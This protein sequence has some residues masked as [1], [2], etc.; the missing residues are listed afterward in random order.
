MVSFQNIGSYA[1]KGATVVNSGVNEIGRIKARVSEYAS[2]A[3]TIL[4][5]VVAISWFVSYARSSKEDKEKKPF[6]KIGPALMVV[7]AIVCGLCAWYQSYVASSTSAY[8]KVMRRSGGA[9]TAVD[10]TG[11]VFRSVRS[12][13]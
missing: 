2:I 5:V 8:A 7:V 9:S 12:L 11:M 6:G 1:V 4:L 10:A 13:F 3:A